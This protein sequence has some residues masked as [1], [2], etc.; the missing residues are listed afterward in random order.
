MNRQTVRVEGCARGAKVDGFTLVELLV[1][2]AII[3]VLVA[4]FLPAAIQAAREAARRT[5]CANHLKQLALGALN[6]ENAHGFLPAGGWGFQWTGDP[7]M[8]YGE[9]QPGGWTYSL[10]GFLEEEGVHQM[11]QASM[12]P[13]RRKRSYSRR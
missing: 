7:N 13:T 9:K 2:I 1:V 10:L 4:V 11:A 8:G 12:M 6:H 3:G 5:E